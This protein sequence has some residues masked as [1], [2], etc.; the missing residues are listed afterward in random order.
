MLPRILAAVRLVVL[1]TMILAQTSGFT[2]DVALA[3][4][5]CPPPAQ[6]LDGASATVQGW[7]INHR[8]LPVDGARTSPPLQLTATSAGGATATASVGA[9]GFFSFDNLTP[10]VWNFSL[11]L[12]QDWD[13]IVPLTPRA[14]LASTGCT[15]LPGRQKPYLIVIKIRRL[16]DVTALKWEELADGTVRP[17]ADWQITFKP[18]NDPFAVKQA[19]TTDAS[20]AANFTVTPGAW[21]IYE[22]VKPGWSPVT[23]PSI[24]LRLDQYAEPGALD[25]VIFK[26]RVPACVGAACDP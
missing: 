21:I 3:Q 18:A 15:A 7:V 2:S 9:D 14:G 24:T 5:A 17:G 1:V 4:P 25:P 23:P 19:R 12:P 11:Q 6:P 13:G 16:F 22:R 26:N 20:G 10:D 8:E